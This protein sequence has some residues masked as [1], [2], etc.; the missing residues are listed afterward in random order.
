LLVIVLAASCSDSGTSPSAFNLAAARDSVTADN[1]KF[2]AD[3][4]RGDS[5]AM[6]AHYTSDAMI[7]PANAE[8]VRGPNILNAWGATVLA[9]VKS[10]DLNTED[11]QGTD[12]LLAE[13]GSYKTWGA[14]KELLDRG[15]YLAVWKR[16]GGKWKI[17]RLISN[18]SLPPQ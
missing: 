10:F 5:V 6:A 12:S 18:T 16:E 13:T 4:E 9:G 17:Y 8:P 1:R 15:K 14:G 3:M 7:L 2:I 11:L